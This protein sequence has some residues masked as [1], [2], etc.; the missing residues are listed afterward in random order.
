M[1]KPSETAL[2]AMPIGTKIDLALVILFI[3]MLVVSAMYQ[4]SSQKAMIEELVHSQTSDTADSYFDNIN[5]L[6]L[7]GGMTNSN[8]ARE[9][10]MAKEDV[11]DARIIRAEPVIKLYGAGP[12]Y[13]RAK[14][15]L[16]KRALAGETIDT[17][18]DNGDGRVLTVIKP[19][20]ATTDF[21]GTNCLGCHVA[22]EGDVLGAVRID[23]SL[24]ALDAKVSEQVWWH[25]ALSTVLMVIGLVCISFILRALVVRPLKITREA[26]TKISTNNDLTVRIPVKSNDEIGSMSS[27]IN[28]MMNKFSGTISGVLESM[29]RLV[30]ESKHLSQMTDQSISGVRKQQQ[31]TNEVATGMTE[32]EQNSI[33]VAEHAS[34]ATTATAQSNELAVTGSSAVNDTIKSIE[35]LAD[36]ITNASKVVQQ[37]EADSESITRV[38]EVISN[39]AEQ[40]NL[41]ALNAAIEAARAGEQGR[42]FAVVA[43]EVRTLAT[44][45]HESTKEIKTM[46][47]KLQTQSQQAAQVMTKSQEHAGKSVE[48]AEHAG[49]VLNRI[50]SAVTEVTN[51]NQQISVASNQQS[52]VAS[53]MSRNVVAINEVTQVTAQSSEELLQVSYSLSDLAVNLKQKVHQFKT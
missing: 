52:E 35:N 17:V 16:D 39:I 51:M 31:E 42:G 53:E 30:D 18:S 41:L 10:V 33:Q 15:E 23:Y 14:D 38:V 20:V 36:E 48:Q 28:Q 45:T 1:S 26:I 47:E 3:I 22:K 7:T 6:M 24:N 21:R 50:T 27:A 46:I 32:M 29:D 25:I 34:V 2:G 4:S 43:D 11:L 19:L 5:T 37:L 13:A 8:I 12:D 49:D 9:K 44:R 40:T